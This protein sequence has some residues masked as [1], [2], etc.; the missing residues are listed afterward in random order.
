MC[1]CW[2]LHIENAVR[3]WCRCLDFWI[4]WEIDVFMLMF[5]CWCLK[6]DLLH[7][8][9]TIN[10]NLL[11]CW[12]IYWCKF[13]LKILWNMWIFFW[14]ISSLA[15]DLNVPSAKIHF[16]GGFLGCHLRNSIFASGWGPPAKITIFSSLLLQAASR[17]LAKV[18]FSPKKNWF[19]SSES[20]INFPS[21][22]CYTLT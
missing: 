14:K 13:V 8:N 6:I 7:C 4:L 16:S 19:C 18:D 12:W 3:S 5:G 17:L 22:C 21:K 2:Y 9:R 11:I 20:S 15:V 10:V 1:M